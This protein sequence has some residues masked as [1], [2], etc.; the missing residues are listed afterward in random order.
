MSPTPA[1][2]EF[3]PLAGGWH[4]VA[5]IPQEATLL[6]ERALATETN[7][8]E[9]VSARVSVLEIRSLTQQ[10]VSGMNY[11]FEVVANA[12]TATDSSQGQALYAINIYEQPWTNTLQV[13][14]IAL[15]AMITGGD[16]TNKHTGS[17]HVKHT[18]TTPTSP[19]HLKAINTTVVD[20]TTRKSTGSVVNAPAKKTTTSSFFCSIDALFFYSVGR[21][22]G[23]SAFTGRV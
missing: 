8:R 3:K 4:P 18:T 2:A 13:T 23:E 16:H 15:L 20:E 19:S 14:G 12:T 11:R 1:T 21:R 22:T 7:Y 9:G 5:S 6:L 17:A 10:V